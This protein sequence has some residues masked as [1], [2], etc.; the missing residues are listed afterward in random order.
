MDEFETQMKNYHIRN[1]ND[2]DNRNKLLKNIKNC[3]DIINKELSFFAIEIAPIFTFGFKTR[4]G[5]V[6]TYSLWIENDGIVELKK[7]ETNGD[8][9]KLTLG[10][11]GDYLELCSDNGLQ[12][13][14]K[15]LEEFI[16]KF[17]EGTL[18]IDYI[19]V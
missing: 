16:K 5:K 15:N 3:I 2:L 18:E 7:V 6:Y 10:Y 14:L 17:E 1:S 19:E 11:W 12:E 4:S 13:I 9:V 8:T